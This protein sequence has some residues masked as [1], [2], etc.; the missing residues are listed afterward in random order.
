MKFL[1]SYMHVGGSIHLITFTL[2]GYAM[3]PSSL[4]MKPGYCMSF[5]INIHLDNFSFK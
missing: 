2:L 1:T 4:I 5:C 3:M